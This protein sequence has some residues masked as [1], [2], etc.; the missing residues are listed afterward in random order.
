ML[1]TNAVIR[2]RERAKAFSVHRLILVRIPEA[3]ETRHPQT[4]IFRHVTSRSPARTCAGRHRRSPRRSIRGRSYQNPYDGVNTFMDNYA[5]YVSVPRSGP[6]DFQERILPRQIMASCKVLMQA[7]V[8]ENCA[9]ALRRPQRPR[10]A[11]LDASWSTRRASTSPWASF[12]SFGTDAL[13]IRCCDRWLVTV[14]RIGR[15]RARGS[16][17]TGAAHERTKLH[18]IRATRGE[19]L[20]RTGRRRRREVALAVRH[21]RGVTK[22]LR[23][24]GGD[25]S[26]SLERVLGFFVVGIELRRVLECTNCILGSP[27]LAQQATVKQ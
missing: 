12:G 5:I 27:D 18:W 19:R 20:R 11:R 4:A 26:E 9:A 8:A 17:G 7:V 25:F 2:M 24:A 1:N 10:L 14:L 3:P 21:W 23:R 22:S 13:K 6:P 15:E 16:T